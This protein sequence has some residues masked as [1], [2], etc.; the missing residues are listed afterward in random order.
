MT[1]NQI[2]CDAFFEDFPGDSALRVSR[3]QGEPWTYLP[4]CE[5]LATDPIEGLPA[6][7]KEATARHKSKDAFP[8]LGGKETS[9]EDLFS[10]FPVEIT[11]LIMDYL[12]SKDIANLR[13]CT[14]RVRQLPNILFRRLALQ[15]MP[16][17]W[18][19]KDM[20]VD[21][22]DWYN[23][24]RLVKFCWAGLK[25]L[26]NRERIWRHAEEIVRRIEVARSKKE[27]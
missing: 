10:E 20:D 1:Y 25:G 14:R 27:I 24:Y 19:M 16:W 26:R 2:K 17:M 13:L 18:E 11:S 12:S 15:E 5:H 23:I 7:P 4:G 3:E 6:L 21:Q 9:P 22:V 8:V